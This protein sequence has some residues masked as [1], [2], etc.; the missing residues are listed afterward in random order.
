MTQSL[1]EVL[2]R[3]EIVI[4]CRD[5]LK[6]IQEMAE[7]LA[8]MSAHDLM[9]LN[10]TVT[11]SYGIDFAHR[12][13]RNTGAALDT[14]IN[15]LRAA[16]DGIN[17][18][19]LRMEGKISD[20]DVMPQNDMAAAG[21][22]GAPGVHPNEPVQPVEHT[23]DF[24]GAPA[25]AGVGAAASQPLGREAKESRLY[26]KKVLESLMGWI[27]SESAKRMTAQN[28][29]KFAQKLTE[30]AQQNPKGTIDWLVEKRKTFEIA[31]ASPSG[32]KRATTA[33]GTALQGK[34]SIPGAGGPSGAQTDDPSA[35]KAT[36]S[37]MKQNPSLK[38][39]FSQSNVD[40]ETLGKALTDPD[41]DRM[42]AT[43]IQ[44][45]KTES[46]EESSGI[47]TSVEPIDTYGIIKGR[48]RME[49]EHKVKM[50]GTKKEL[51]AAKEIPVDEYGENEADHD[52]MKPDYKYRNEIEE[53]INS[54]VGAVDTHGQ[55]KSKTDVYEP[56]YGVI[57]NVKSTDSKEPAVAKTKSNS[58]QDI[59]Q[60]RGAIEP[61]GEYKAKKD[62]IKPDFNSEK[63]PGTEKNINQTR[64][65]TEPTGE[66]KTKTKVYEPDF[67][68]GGQSTKEK[69][70]KQ[71]E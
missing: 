35:K 45:A 34:K 20:E 38:T 63:V 24:A 33:L 58:I 15:G 18:E 55:Y 28:L 6:K 2:E 10:D 17:L 14:A 42:I 59:N 65:P 43:K 40:S 62:V 47:T 5:I 4:A 22:P 31:L 67:K 16:K 46:V 53:N 71:K 57:M 70:Q 39:A 61:T 68:E 36:S 25:A 26:S 69:P 13:E 48:D 23:D 1:S 9:P 12:F 44:K 8:K 21:I 49:P 50:R 66:Y 3:A 11:S 7:D 64:G 30:K 19:V 37:L 32:I 41:V 60:S 51:N 52:E 29:A 56:D 27:I 54:T